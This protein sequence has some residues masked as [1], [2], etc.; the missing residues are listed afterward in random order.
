MRL[1]PKRHKP[2]N[3]WVSRRLEVL[4]NPPYWLRDSFLIGYRR[5]TITLFMLSAGVAAALGRLPNQWTKRLV[6]LVEQALKRK[7]RSCNGASVSNLS[8]KV[9]ANGRG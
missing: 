4:K 5:G 1:R 3:P 6:P 9:G 2:P 7:A 8:L